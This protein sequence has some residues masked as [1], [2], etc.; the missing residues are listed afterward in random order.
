M[1]PYTL[2]K[3]TEP[4]GDC[5]I[6]TIDEGCKLVCRPARSTLDLQVSSRLL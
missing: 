1:S 3:W 6:L 5:S 4:K 2:S